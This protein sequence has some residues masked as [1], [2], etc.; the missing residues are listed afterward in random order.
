M[1]DND[2]T[3]RGQRGSGWDI[4]VVYVERKGRWWWNAWRAATST[5]L[6]GVTDSRSDAWAA[7]NAAIHAHSQA[8]QLLER[9]NR[10]V[11][12]VA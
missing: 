4:R 2:T 3:A 6:Y 9:R 12:G 10:P 7:M 8:D 1:N 11:G 5:E